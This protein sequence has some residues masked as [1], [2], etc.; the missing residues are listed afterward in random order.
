MR[1]VG[2]VAPA[3]VVSFRLR[4]SGLFGPELYPRVPKVTRSDILVISPPRVLVLQQLGMAD[5]WPQ[6]SQAE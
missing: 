4:R 2:A 6:P 1:F 5:A 3:A